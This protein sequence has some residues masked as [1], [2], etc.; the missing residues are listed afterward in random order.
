[1]H[2]IVESEKKMYGLMGSLKIIRNRNDKR[3]IESVPDVGLSSQQ[4]QYLQ[5]F[6]ICDYFREEW[7]FDG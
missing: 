1:V 3:E 5:A 4:H 7:F 2:L 6:F